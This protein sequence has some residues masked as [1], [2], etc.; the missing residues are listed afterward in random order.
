MLMSWLTL[1]E[2]WPACDINS[3]EVWCILLHRPTIVQVITL[4]WL[5]HSRELKL[6]NA[7][8]VQLQVNLPNIHPRHQRW[9]ACQRFFW[10]R[11]QTKWMIWTFLW[12]CLERTW[13]LMSEMLQEMKK[14]RRKGKNQ[15]GK[16]AKTNHGHFCILWYR[17]VNQ[18]IGVS[19]TVMR[20]D[21]GRKNHPTRSTKWL[22]L[23][24]T[25]L[26]FKLVHLGW[27]DV[28]VTQLYSAAGA[29]H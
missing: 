25:H 22:T 13:I 21:A 11:K 3:S 28:G 29:A 15:E 1:A 5:A 9:T 24:Y 7:H 2:L 19:L 12:T 6:L 18:C 26:T 16:M 20:H 10:W 27:T 17:W 14:W 8:G 23:T 4:S